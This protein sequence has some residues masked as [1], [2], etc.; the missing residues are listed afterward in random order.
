MPYIIKNSSSKPVRS[1]G[2]DFKPGENTI[3][4]AELTSAQL[5][6]IY[7]VPVLTV[8]S[9]AESKAVSNNTKDAKS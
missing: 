7:A 4:D 2:I 3:P 6:Q 9:A 1:A 8:S 5:V